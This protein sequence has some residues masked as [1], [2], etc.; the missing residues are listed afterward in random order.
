[1]IKIRFISYFLIFIIFPKYDKKQPMGGGT[2]R[3]GL[4]TFRGF[5][6]ERP[7]LGTFNQNFKIFTQNENL[8]AQR[9]F[10]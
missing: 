2:E 4:S 10:F 8:P 3:A 1:M 5:D 7:R 9:F 6:T